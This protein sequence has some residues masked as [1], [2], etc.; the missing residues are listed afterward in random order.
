MIIK[1][2]NMILMEI[3]FVKYY[4][5]YYYF[6]QVGV[7]KQGNIQYLTASVYTDLGCSKNENV[8]IFVAEM[9]PNCYDNTRFAL[10]AYSVLTEKPSTTWMRAPGIIMSKISKIINYI[11]LFYL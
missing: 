5:S 8:N 7:N 3:V 4:V 1:Y 10:K 2:V 11:K 6:A 9:F